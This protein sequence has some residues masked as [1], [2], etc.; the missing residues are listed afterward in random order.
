MFHHQHC[1]EIIDAWMN[2]V[3][4]TGLVDGFEH[5]TCVMVFFA[6]DDLWVI[7]PAADFEVLV[8]FHVGKDDFLVTAVTMSRSPEMPRKK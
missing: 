6:N 2:P 4:F 3:K 5:I 7:F 8:L 1:L